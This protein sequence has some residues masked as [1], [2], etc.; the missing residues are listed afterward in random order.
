MSRPNFKQDLAF[1]QQGERNFMALAFKHGVILHQTDG[2]HGDLRDK[3]G[4]VWE[5]KVDRYDHAKTSNLFLEMYSDV[6]KGK[7][8]GPGQA[9][10]NDCLYFAYYFPNPGIA[11]I[12]LTKDLVEQMKQIDLGQP[13]YIQNT[14]WCSVGYAVNRSLLKPEFVWHSK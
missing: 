10:L 2:R 6:D 8:G 1:G 3:Q 11:Y 5:V 14:K 13:K 7:L 4:N 12:F 9:L